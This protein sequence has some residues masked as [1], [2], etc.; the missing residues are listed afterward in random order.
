MNKN[1]KGNDKVFRQLLVSFTWD[2]VVRILT[3]FPHMSLLISV[4]QFNKQ[5]GMERCSLVNR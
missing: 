5:R 2:S 1:S 3:M 4:V